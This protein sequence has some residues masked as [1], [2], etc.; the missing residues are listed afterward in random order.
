MTLR[1]KLLVAFTLTVLGA[2]GLLTWGVT[3]YVRQEFDA[4]DRQRSE[5]LAAQFQR[6]FALRGE[7]VANR[8]QD[9]ADAEGTLRMALD[10]GR[11]QADF[12]LYAGDARG[13]AATHRLDFL[14]LVANGVLISSAQYPAQ[15]GNQN[16]WVAGVSGWNQSSAFLRPVDL[17]DGAQLALT[18]VRDVHAGSSDLYIIG[19]RRVD[20]DFLRTFVSPPGMRVL[21]Y[22]NL[23]PSSDPAVHP[24]AIIGAEGP[25]S[26]A[27]RFAPLLESAAQPGTSEDTIQWS[28][29]PASAE[30]FL[31]VP[32]AGRKNEPL[33]TLLIGS[34]Q[35]DYAILASRIRAL[36]LVI[37]GAATL[38]SIFLG[39][40]ISARI[41]RPLA[42]LETAARQIADGR[43]ID[44]RIAGA[45]PAAPLPAR[46][47]DE[48]GRAARAFNAMARKLSEQSR[49]SQEAERAV[50]RREIAR[51]LA[52]EVK[53][54]LFPLQVAVENLRRSREQ[55]PES[56]GESLL[57]SLATLSAE[58][59]KLKGTVAR[60]SNFAKMPAPRLQ[61]LSANDAVRAALKAFEPQ[62]N[63]IGRPPVTPELFLNERLDCIAA[64]PQLL[65]KALESLLYRSLDSMPAGG[66]LAIRTAQDGGLVRIEVS[67]TGVGLT[68]EETARLFTP[69]YVVGAQASGLGLATVQSVVTEHGGK[70][71]AES[72][73]GAGTTFRIEF[74]AAPE[75]PDPGLP[76]DE[77]AARPARRAPP[78]WAEQEPETAAPSRIGA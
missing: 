52:H 21:L 44:G 46:S 45:K 43:V 12:S 70:I 20:A 75:I 57:D 4:S 15:I 47:R 71:S 77:P 51:R 23:Q 2:T 31:A 17:P 49:Q 63:A 76:A 18:A 50:A 32:L 5:A 25:V 69:Y 6:E 65:S 24:E 62:F 33:A 37:A 74:P 66:T 42:R 16:D 68:P 22:P 30:R 1:T 72:V 8:V 59:E 36:A 40:W 9:I 55:S 35:K 41:A 53:E 29:D 10:L 34:Q 39:W 73:P 67:D 27:E 58:L 38:L 48:V 54:R 11:P 7:E 60:F 14:E 78:Q 61:P 3:Q 19:G 56:S 64:D 28:E 13:L 26:N